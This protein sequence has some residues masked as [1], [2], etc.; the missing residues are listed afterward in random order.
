MEKVLGTLD[1]DFFNKVAVAYRE[2]ILKCTLR[3]SLKNS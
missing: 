2:T 1:V 3:W